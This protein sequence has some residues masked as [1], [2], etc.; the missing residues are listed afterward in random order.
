MWTRSPRR[1]PC[2][3]LFDEMCWP[4]DG[5]PGDRDQSRAPEEGGAPPLLP[6]DSRP[7]PTESDGQSDRHLR[8]R[9]AGSES[10][11]RSN[12]VTG[13]RTVTERNPGRLMVCSA[14]SVK[15]AATDRD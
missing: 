12:T 14:G 13:T 2:R 8:R 4:R 10:E 5:P 15:A 9:A 3:R 7:G 1:R 11:S 6:L